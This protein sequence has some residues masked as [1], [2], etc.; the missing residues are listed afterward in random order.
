MAKFDLHLATSN[1][2][3]LRPSQPL[4]RWV[5]DPRRKGPYVPGHRDPKDNSVV[6]AEM[7]EAL[8]T[9]QMDGAND[10]L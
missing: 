10:K 3:P 8:R 7:D 1:P 4:Q 6:I 5:E 2:Y 9:L